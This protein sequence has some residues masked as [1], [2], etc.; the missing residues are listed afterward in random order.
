MLASH[1]GDEALAP[2]VSLAMLTLIGATDMVSVAIWQTL[3][4]LWTPQRY[5]AG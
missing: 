1:G 4:Q 5:G 3:I 2:E